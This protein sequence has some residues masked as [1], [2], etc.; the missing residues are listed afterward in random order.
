[1][2]AVL[3]IPVLMAPTSTILGEIFLAILGALLILAPI[4]IPSSPVL[5]PVLAPILSRS[6]PAPIRNR[7]SLG[8]P[9]KARKGITGSET[10]KTRSRPEI[11]R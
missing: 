1:M 9:G 2:R 11:R 5:A 10:A 4:P 6:S 7:T 3:L 8:S